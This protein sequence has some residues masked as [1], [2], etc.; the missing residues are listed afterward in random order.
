MNKMVTPRTIETATVRE[1]LD[2][3]PEVRRY[4]LTCNPD[5]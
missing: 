1:L 4:L 2:L 3:S 5:I